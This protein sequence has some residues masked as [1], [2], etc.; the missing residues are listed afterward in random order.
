MRSILSVAVLA[1]ALF[2]GS[3]AWA[4]ATTAGLPTA[5]QSQTAQRVTAHAQ[6]V[7]ASAPNGDDETALAGQYAA[8]EAKAKHLENFQGG[9]TTVV[10]ST[11]TIII[12]LLI[13]LI[14]VRI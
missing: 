2:S 8:R 9:S 13:V 11:S 5:P 12:V 6:P 1:V 4:H 7:T 3:S 10:I 14:L